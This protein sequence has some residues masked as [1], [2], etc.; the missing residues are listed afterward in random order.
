LAAT[1]FGLG[2]HIQTLAPAGASWNVPLVTKS[3]G[4]GCKL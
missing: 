1:G 2:R 3:R 4:P